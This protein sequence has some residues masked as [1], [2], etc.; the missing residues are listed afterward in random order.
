MQL[1]GV[2]PRMERSSFALQQRLVALGAAEASAR[3][4]AMSLVCAGC[5]G[6]HPPASGSPPWLPGSRLRAPGSAVAPGLPCTLSRPLRAPR[7]FAG[8]SRGPSVHPAEP[9]HCGARFSSM[10]EP[11]AVVENPQNPAHTS[12]PPAVISLLI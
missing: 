7:T 8:S 3:V 11:D 6:A 12:S 9:A 4:A 5:R 1:Q 10:S 2:D